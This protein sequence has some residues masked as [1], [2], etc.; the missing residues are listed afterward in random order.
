MEL[1]NE[2]SVGVPVEDAWAVLTDLERIAPCLPGARLEEVQGEEY[3][4]IVKVKVG[5]ITAQYKGAATFVERD[6]AGRRVVLRAAGRDARGQGNAEATIVATM[7][8]DAVGTR[9]QI[10]TNLTITGKVA[11]FGRGV[12]ADVSSKLLSQFVER[13]EAD[14]LGQGPVE[15]EQAPAPPAPASPPGAPADGV[16]RISS[17]AATEPVDLLATAGGPVTRRL[18]PALG[19]FALFLVVRR[20]WRRR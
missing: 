13:L 17:P 9:V 19:V 10:V 20:L 3:R 6:E 11:Q 1:K 16:R 4:G 7:E 2:F 8:P 14:V 15:P 5:P 12:L 18:V